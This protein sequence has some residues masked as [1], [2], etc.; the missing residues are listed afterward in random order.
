MEHWI[1]VGKAN[2]IANGEWQTI[3]YENQWLIVANCEGTF[4]AIEDMCTHD[5]GTLSD[6]DIKGE[7]II[8]PRH[9]ARFCLRTGKATLPPAYEDIHT[10]P[11]R[12]H[13]GVIQVD[14]SELDE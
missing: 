12:I 3:E 9:G 4:Y 10:F 5:G 7:E 13:E 6:G 1:T 14:V 11:V 2:T 8:C